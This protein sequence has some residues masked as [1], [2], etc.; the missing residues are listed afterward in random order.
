MA[1]QEVNQTSGA[2]DASPYQLAL[3]FN[4]HGVHQLESGNF[5][6]ARRMFLGAMEEIKLS[7]PRETPGLA[8]RITNA[9]PRVKWSKNAQILGDMNT[10]IMWSDSFV[11]RRALVME[12]IPDEHLPS[13]DFEVESTVIIYN[14]ALSL[15]IDGFATNTSNLLTL[16]KQL[17]EIALIRETDARSRNQPN[18]EFLHAAICNNLGWIHGELCN[19]DFAAYYFNGVVGSM[20]MMDQSALER[21]NVHDSQGFIMNL[22]WSVHPYAAAAA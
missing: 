17:F 16:A 5:H 7:C 4:N 9:K 1:T 20:S 6:G 10:Q 12:P 8:N 21:L 15:L 19:Y 3:I 2:M 11:F 22:F 13:H 14:C 18:Q